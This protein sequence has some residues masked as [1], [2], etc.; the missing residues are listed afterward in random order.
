MS[1]RSSKTENLPL[2]LIK[3]MI[4]LRQKVSE[5]EKIMSRTFPLK[6]VQKQREQTKENFKDSRRKK[7]KKTRKNLSPK[8]KTMLK[9][10][11]QMIPHLIK[12]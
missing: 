4:K 9:I 11:H 3:S 1:T 2:L 7:S 10:R 6:W 12:A 8:R 5:A